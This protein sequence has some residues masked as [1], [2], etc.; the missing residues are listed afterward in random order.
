M[1]KKRESEV[2]AKNPSPPDFGS[3]NVLLSTLTKRDL[4]SEERARLCQAISAK[5]DYLETDL[6]KD[7]EVLRKGVESF[8]LTMAGGKPG[9]ISGYSVHLQPEGSGRAIMIEDGAADAPESKRKIKEM[10]DACISVAKEDLAFLKGAFKKI[11]QDGSL[12]P[13][14]LSRLREI[15]EKNTYWRLIEAT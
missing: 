11:N 15:L 3:V 13:A 6:A 8:I 2:A 1:K 12:P 9:E 7:A 14:D 4:K 10:V 5:I